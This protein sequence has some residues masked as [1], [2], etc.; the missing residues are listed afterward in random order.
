MDWQIVMF[1]RLQDLRDRAMD[2]DGKCL[3]SASE[4]YLLHRLAI[5]ESHCS[6]MKLKK[7]CLPCAEFLRFEEED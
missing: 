7:K 1:H 4:H 3:K 6:R 2:D 5:L